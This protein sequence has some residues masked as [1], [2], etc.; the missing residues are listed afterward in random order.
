VNAAPERVGVVGAS[1]RAAVHSLARAGIPAW[2]VDLFGD[3]D[4]Q[5]IASWARCP[6]DHYPVALPEIAKSFPPGPVLLTGGMENHPRAVAALAAARELWGTPPEAL[7]RVRD[8]HALAA[9]LAAGG[10]A[11]PRLLPPGKAC[12][13]TG[14]W[15]LKAKRSSA[16]LG[17]RL[18]KAG[19]KADASSHLQEFVAG[20]PMSAVYI[21]AELFGATEQLIGVDWLH[22]RGFHYAGNIGP[23]ALAPRL[24]SELVRLGEHLSTE[25]GL[26]SAF[27]V[28]FIVK[29]DRA[30]VVEVNPRYP[31]SVEVIEHAC[32]VPVFG[33]PSPNLFPR[34]GRGLN[35]AIVAKAIY[36]APHRI[37]FPAAGPWDADLASPFNPWRLPVFADIPEVGAIIDAGWPVLTYFAG[38]SS[39]VAVRE[40]L[41][42]RAAELDVLFA[43]CQP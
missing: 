12:P 28:D 35:P 40:R 20:T 38:G 18:A 13:T 22:A 8:P 9:A 1:A 43:E 16:G 10:F 41:Q 32:G 4:L 17:V 6:M 27:G 2:G 14:R 37:A 5:H 25:F 11:H 15:L 36:Y 29:G 30:L 23:I 31:A 42:S 7:Q 3:R 26:R 39:P 33:N 34:R 21:D 24:K 19:E